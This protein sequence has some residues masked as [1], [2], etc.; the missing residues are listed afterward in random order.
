MNRGW[1]AG[2]MIRILVEPR[3]GFPANESPINRRLS[4]HKPIHGFT[5]Y[6]D[7]YAR[8]GAFPGAVP[9]VTGISRR[10]YFPFK[11]MDVGPFW[12]IK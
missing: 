3:P 10:L 12:I 9:M 8:R 11:L 4:G 7:A 2:L 6:L 5:A 1:N